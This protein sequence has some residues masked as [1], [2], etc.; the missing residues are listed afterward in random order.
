MESSTALP[1]MPLV[2][3]TTPL[4][5]RSSRSL[6]PRQRTTT[7]IL[8]SDPASSKSVAFLLSGDERGVPLVLV[9]ATDSARDVRPSNM[10]VADRPRIRLLAAWRAAGGRMEEVVRLVA[11]GAPGLGR[12]DMSC[13]LAVVVLAKLATVM[14]SVLMHVNIKTW[15]AR[16]RVGPKH[17]TGGSRFVMP[18]HLNA[19]R[20]RQ[21]RRSR[22]TVLLLCFAYDIHN[23]LI[24]LICCKK[25]LGSWKADA[26]IVDRKLR[27]ALNCAPQE[28][29][30]TS[31]AQ[32]LHPAAVHSS[33]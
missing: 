24:T 11:A 6:R 3:T 5:S 1:L 12:P 19:S 30:L 8:V 15:A 21:P 32:Q 13:L 31:H 4:F 2:V 18:P 9:E 17:A 22:A 23:R 28:P 14:A 20:C 7:L 25:Y 10:G 29:P 33:R 27:T 26:S 16:V